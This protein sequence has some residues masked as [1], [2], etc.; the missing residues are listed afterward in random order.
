MVFEEA[1][2][3]VSSF[4]TS[5][6]RQ[7]CLLDLLFVGADAFHCTSGRGLADTAAMLETLACVEPCEQYSFSELT[8]LVDR[9]INK[10]NSLICVLLDLSEDR[11][12]WLQRLAQSNTPAICLIIH[13]DN[14]SLDNIERYRTQQLHIH[15]FKVGNLQEQLDALEGVTPHST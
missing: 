15:T 6:Q 4:I 5:M 3:V 1:V 10:F 2:S 12:A 7:D 9:N 13:D 14:A 8:N 11:R